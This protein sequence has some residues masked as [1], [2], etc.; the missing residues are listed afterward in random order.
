[1]VK[2]PGE[3]K[4]GEEKDPPK[5]RGQK[6]MVEV[7]DPETEITDEQ[8]DEQIHPIVIAEGNARGERHLRGNAMSQFA[9]DGGADESVVIMHPDDDRPIRPGDSVAEIIDGEKGQNQKTA[10]RKSGACPGQAKG[11]LPEG[12]DSTDLADKDINGR[13]RDPATE[14]NFKVQKPGVFIEERACGHSHDR[15]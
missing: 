11:N 15:G 9:D 7:E 14:K 3:M 1:M 10:A 8:G 12:G 2:G 4:G 5:E 13:G 6:S